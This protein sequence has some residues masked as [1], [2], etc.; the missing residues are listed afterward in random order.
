MVPA[1]R[2]LRASRPPPCGPRWRAFQFAPGELVELCSFELQR[3]Q[4]I[5]QNKRVRSIRKWCRHQDYSGHPALRPA[6]RAGARSNSLPANWSNSARSNCSDLS[7]F[8]KTNV[9]EV[10]ENGAGTKIRTRDLLI[11]NQ[12]LYQLSYT[13]TVGNGIFLQRGKNIQCCVGFILHTTPTGRVALLLKLH[14]PRVTFPC[15]SPAHP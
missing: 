15:Y 7:A 9:Y 8:A 6:G 12:L 13:G 2:L 5:R 10:L 11:T 14:F 3:P 1:P 4:R